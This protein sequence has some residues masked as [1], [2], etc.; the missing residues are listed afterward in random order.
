[1]AHV[2]TDANAPKA[3]KVKTS[4][5]TR[6]CDGARARARDARQRARMR[7][8]NGARARVSTRVS[9]RRRRARRRGTH[10]RPRSVG[11]L[12]V[13]KKKSSHPTRATANGR[14]RARE[15]MRA[16]GEVTKKISTRV[17]GDDGR[18]RRGGGISNVGS[19]GH[20]L[21]D[22][23]SRARETTTTTTTTTTTHVDAHT[24]TYDSTHVGIYT[25]HDARR[26]R[27]RRR[28]TR[29]GGILER[30]V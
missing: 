2:S 19:D 26:R 27:R 24:Y 5:S 15:T 18:R 25:T 30:V 22:W 17:V 23:C 12:D 3:P 1:M 29:D 4:P 6:A 10:G 28:T 9:T 11:R 16:I 13:Q 21:V 8:N 7:E 14:E 20:R